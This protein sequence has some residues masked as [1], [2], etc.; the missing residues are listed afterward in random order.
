[1]VKD[2]YHISDM[3][4]F[5]FF[6]NY[7]RCDNKRKTNYQGR[8]KGWCFLYKENTINGV[9]MWL[10]NTLASINKRN[11]VS[12]NP[13]YEEIIGLQNIYLVNSITK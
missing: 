8:K 11:K 3:C 2:P 7:K 6:V 13:E 9:D 1:M 12:L 10:R 5:F 4:E